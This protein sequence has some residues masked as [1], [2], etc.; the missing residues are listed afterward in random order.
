MYPIRRPSHS[1]LIPIRHLRYHV[2]QWGQPRAGAT[3]WVMVHGWMDVSASFQFVVDALP[4]DP[5]IIAPDWRGFGRTASSG[6]DSFWFADYLADLD[7]LL[8]HLCPGQ[9]VHLIGHS[10]GGHAATLYAGVRP[11]RVARLVNLEGF[12]MPATRPAQAPTRLAQWIDELHAQHRGDAGLRPYASLADVAARLMKTNPRL[13]ADKAHWLAQH[14]A[15][16]DAQGQWHILG[17]AGHKIVNPYLF[18]VDETL[19]TYARIQAPTL[20]VVAESDSID[21]WWKDR[22]SL[23]EF[24]ARFAH[25]PQVQHAR[26]ADCGH[27]LH[28][29]QPEVLAQLLHG[30]L[31]PAPA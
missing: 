16:Q 17:E 3:P 14:W 7:F 10:M 26:L 20:C 8:E 13:A 18:R 23:A 2:R 30:F 6:Q 29:D 1:D 4:E 22:Y 19:A 28:H 31:E 12:G 21:Q 27:M 25:V 15:R 9:P 11:E 5:W 24:M